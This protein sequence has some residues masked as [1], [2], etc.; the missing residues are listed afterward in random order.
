MKSEARE[1]EE[2]RMFMKE[3]EGVEGGENV[4]L[5]YLPDLAL[6]L[7]SHT[8]RDRDKA[9]HPALLPPAFRP[10]PFSHHRILTIPYH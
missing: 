2:R 6:P 1:K 9:T 4:E 3:E 7:A 10:W 5:E 8:I